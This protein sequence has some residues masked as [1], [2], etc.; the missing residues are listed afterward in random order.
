[1]KEEKGLTYRDA[2]VDIDAQDEAL[3]RI[4]DALVATRTPGVLADLGAFGGLFAPDLKGMEAPV[5]VASADGVGTKLDVAV[6]AGVHDTVGRDLVNH[7]VNDILVQGAR[8]LFFLD[9]VATG[10]LDP[11]VLAAVV[12]GIAR[13]CRENG[14]ALLGGETAEMPGF[15]GDGRYDVAGFI[16]GMV[17]RPKVLDGSRVRVGDALVGLPSAGL[18]TNGYSLARKLFFDVAGLAVRDHVPALGT[19]VEEALLAEHRSYLPV[20][21]GALDAGLVAALAHITGGGLTDN[22]PRIL[23]QGTAAEIR[24]GSWPLPTLFRWMQETGKIAESE[25]RRT[26]NLG[27]GM[28]A[29]VPE[30]TLQAFEAHLDGRGEPHWRIGRVVPG[31]R[32]VVYA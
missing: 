20:L 25:M 15:Y 29:V 2:G 24:T 16:V 30:A 19:T 14:C 3:R 1:M 7:C 32:E 6:L 11:A 23:P 31:D 13:G 4:K 22:I 18:H 12:S 26:F 21:R 9:Y 27:I 17:D 10:R 5:L 28:V 8:P